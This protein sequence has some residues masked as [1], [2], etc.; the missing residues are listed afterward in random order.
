MPIS[1]KRAAGY[2]CLIAVVL[3]LLHLATQALRKYGGY[4]FQLGFQRQFDLG[5]ENNIP[6][7][8]SSSMLLACSLL[9]GLIGWAKR[10][11]KASDASSWVGLAAVFLFLSMDEASSLHEMTGPAGAK[12]LRWA[13][14]LHPFLFYSW[15]PFG[16]TAVAIIGL[17]YLPFLRA[18]P[19]ETRR[20]VLL[21]GCAYIS[22]AV[23]A[24]MVGG[25]IDYF[26][27]REGMPLAAVVATEE[28]LEMFGIIVFLY[29]LL[30]YLRQEDVSTAIRQRVQYLFS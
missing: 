25:A 2:L 9:L 21:A 16:I 20:R 4:D 30:M 26:G 5:K 24:E 8:F 11:T 15:L 22:G 13:G 17:L 19:K 3:I 1:P 6:T 27:G 7:W 14:L 29:A 10:G 12:L 18:L 28:G 23:I